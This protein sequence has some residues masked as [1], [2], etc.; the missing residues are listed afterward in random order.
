MRLLATLTIL[1]LFTGAV[2]RSVSPGYKFKKGQVLEYRVV[3][4]QNL[5]MTLERYTGTIEQSNAYTLLFE[6]KEATR[7]EVNFIF[8]LKDVQV[9]A[10]REG[11]KML[12]PIAPPT[13]DL[14]SLLQKYVLHRTYFVRMDVYGN[15][16]SITPPEYTFK[17]YDMDTLQY[18]ALMEFTNRENIR[19]L[20]NSA[21]MVYPRN[22]ITPGDAWNNYVY[23]D[24]GLPVK[25][26]HMLSIKET[27]ATKNKF[28]L[29]GSFSPSTAPPTA[30]KGTSPVNQIS[31]PLQG[32]VSTL[33]KNGWVLQKE[34]SGTLR[35][36]VWI[37]AHKVLLENTLTF[38]ASKQN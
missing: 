25:A 28:L 36:E 26:S 35:G 31:G 32:K 29:Q 13:F 1:S 23:L 9:T 3:Q 16:V 17:P 30:S 34:W 5:Q 37:D 24:A 33:K 7:T 18:D 22:H 14:D 10:K 11:N 38:S 2:A 15:V 8:K 27:T 21:F 20:V 4:H 6:V 12:G 19:T